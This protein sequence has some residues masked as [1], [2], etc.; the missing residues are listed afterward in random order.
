MINPNRMYGQILVAGY[1]STR[2]SSTLSSIDDQMLLAKLFHVLKGPE[3][4]DKI[5]Q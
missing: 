4:R 3:N 5:I 1:P 2:L